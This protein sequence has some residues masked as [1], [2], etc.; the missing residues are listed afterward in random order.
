MFSSE[1]LAAQCAFVHAH[2]RRG[3]IKVFRTWWNREVRCFRRLA[4]ASHLLTLALSM[5]L[6]HD[7]G[8]FFNVTFKFS[9]VRTTRE[10]R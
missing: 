7:P 3:L 4:H 2:R 8:D 5:N 9:N 1:H 10:P 6:F